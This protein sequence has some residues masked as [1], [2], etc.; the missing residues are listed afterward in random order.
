MAERQNSLQMAESNLEKR[1]QKLKEYDFLDEVTSARGVVTGLASLAALLSGRSDIAGGLVAKGALNA[2]GDYGVGKQKLAMEEEKARQDVQAEKGVVQADL[3]RQIG[4]GQIDPLTFENEQALS[5]ATG[6]S[7]EVAKAYRDTASNKTALDQREEA[8][9]QY[10]ANSPNWADEDLIP[11]TRTYMELKGWPADMYSDDEILDMHRE[12]VTQDMFLRAAQTADPVSYQKAVAHLASFQGTESGMNEAAYAQA[13]QMLRPQLSQGAAYDAALRGQEQADM[14]L[15]SEWRQLTQAHPD[16]NV[17]QVKSALSLK[18]LNAYYKR[19]AAHKP[20]LGDYTRYEDLF[21]EARNSLMENPNFSYDPNGK[22]TQ[23]E[24]VT[25]IDEFAGAQ[26]NSAYLYGQRMRENFAHQVET[27]TLDALA[28][29]LEITNRDD[30]PPDMLPAIRQIA[31]KERLAKLQVEWEA[32][33]KTTGFADYVRASFGESFSFTADAEDFATIAPVETNQTVDDNAPATTFEKAQ[34]KNLQEAASAERIKDS[35]DFR[36]KFIDNPE[37]FS[38]AAGRKVAASADP[39][40]EASK[41][42]SGWLRQAS[43]NNPDNEA[44]KAIEWAAEK[45][46]KQGATNPKEFYNSMVILAGEYVQQRV[47]SM[48]A[49]ESASTPKL[50]MR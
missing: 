7:A 32:G 24:W 16:W 21:V 45:A 19:D 43:I 9:A 18:A 41:V 39:D 30:I 5:D 20:T 17:E 10:W 6:W 29:S 22:L 26:A 14:Q 28:A 1:Q 36:N 38:F 12:G 48:E 31:L 8:A 11:N 33:D 25:M 3:R 4:L 50:R 15:T 27:A 40:T 46:R 37:T 44:E 2:V 35:A 42:V 23:E 34:A 49:E 13:I 47:R